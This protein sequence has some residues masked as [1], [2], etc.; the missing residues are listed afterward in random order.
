MAYV[1]VFAAI[2]CIIL[3]VRRFAGI[4]L[5]LY[6][7]KDSNLSEGQIAFW[8]RMSGYSLLFW[9][10]FSVTMAAMMLFR[11]WLVVIPLAILAAGGFVFSMKGSAA[12]HDKTGKYDNV[13]PLESRVMEQYGGKPKK[14]KKKKKK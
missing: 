7:T 2:Y 9:A 10:G 1:F 4:K 13:P 3:C 12:L 5:P 8:S 6:I 14:K 11:H